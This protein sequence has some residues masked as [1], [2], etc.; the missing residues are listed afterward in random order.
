MTNLAMLCCPPFRPD[1][2]FIL[3]GKPGV[4]MAGPDGLQL[5]A[6]DEEWIYFDQDEHEHYLF[7]DGLLVGWQRKAIV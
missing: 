6:R 1:E 5:S 2:I 3:R 4:K 7:S